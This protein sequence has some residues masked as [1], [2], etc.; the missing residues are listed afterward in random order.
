MHA[1]R[2]ITGRIVSGEEQKPVPGA[3]VKVKGSSKVTSTDADGKFS[4]SAGDRDVLEITS[5]GFAAR[6]VKA[7]SNLANLVLATESTNL[8]EVVVTALGVKKETKRIG[9][10][11]QEVKGSDLVKAREPNPINSL[12]GKVAGLDV[13]ISREML[14]A[15]SVSLRGGNISLYVVDGMPITSDTWN[16]SPDDIETYT[17]LKGL[18]ATALYG[19]RAQNGAILITTKKGKKNNKGYTI[20]FNSS[21]QVDKGFIALPKTQALYGGGDYSQ[22]AFGDGKGGGINDGDYDVW[23]PKFEGQLIPQ[24]DSP[25]D[26]VTG[27]RKGTPYIAR[28]KDN[29]KNFIQAGILNTNNLSFSAASDRATIR[30]SLSES[31]QKGIIPNTKLDIA[32]FNVNTSYDLSSKL[33]IE[34]N[35][36]YNRQ[37]TPNIPDVQYG[38]NSVIYNMTIW[39]GADWNVLDPNIRNYW[40]PGKEGIQSNFAEYQRYHNPWFMSYEWLRGHYKTDVFGNIA[41]NYKANN[42]IDATLRA[43]VSTYDVLRNEKMP[44]S[45]HPYGREQNRGDYREDRRS[46]FDNN[47]EGLVKYHGQIAKTFT[48]NALA[49][50]NVRNFKYN[51]SYVTTDYLNVPGLYSF[52]NSLNPI[53]AYSYDADMIVLSGYYSADIEFK[54]YLSVT[55]TGRLDKSSSLRKNNNSYFYPSVSAASVISDYVSLPRF[56]SFLKLR[57]SYATAKAPDIANYIGPAAYPIGYGAPYVTTFG[58]PAYSLSDPAYSISTVYNSQTGASAPGNKIDPNVKSSVTTSTELGLDMRFLKNRVAFSATYY[59]NILGPRIVNVPLSE[60]TG[61]TGYS[62][63]AIKTKLSGVELALSGTP[64]QNANGF[65]WDVMANWSTYKEVFK[66]LPS[67]FENYQFHQG[68]RVDKLFATVTAK[69]PD[70]QVINNSAGYPVYLPKQQ[71][72]GN[73]DVDWSW[74]VNNK[75]SYKTFSLSFQ[76]DGKVGGI[77]QDYVKRKSIEGGS[78][79]ETVQ[80]K[81]GEA[82][83]YEF[84]HYNDPGFKG[85]YIGEGVQIS[86]GAAIQYDPT[87]GVITNSKDLAFK[88]NASPAKYIQDYVSSFFN[89][90]EHTSV[91]KT[92]AKLREVVITYSVPVKLLGKQSFISRVDVSLVGR[93]LLYFFPSRFH[94]IDVDQYSGRN[95]SGGNSREPNLQTPTTRSYGFNLNF[96]F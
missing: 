2:T 94:D 48:V 5:I 67:N 95:I 39:T 76:F 43:N 16:I 21:I 93:N 88:P 34:G 28:G 58:G 81:V 51:S 82:R 10:S 36:N 84:H 73:G 59:S 18:A 17:V 46:L 77:V 85:T 65:R 64:V 15:P 1:Q 91:A 90:F 80:G 14:A 68:D 56:M 52:S 74:A 49:G 71:Y 55:T 72:V 37:A 41:L 50:G 29:L 96:V 35:L 33:K 63:N 6:E 78:N 70:G 89:N 62:S 87:T 25:I 60:T 13:A 53:K 83:D 23:G 69:T 38:P 32:N 92:Y 3:T 54:N 19:S 9:Y 66:D 4:I 31:H 8:N 86:N 11:V 26:P 20:E 27:I 61:L 24:Y 30:M 12:V 47:I 7:N 75:I 79:I 40:Q 42:H 57:A 22:Y 45:A 44:Y